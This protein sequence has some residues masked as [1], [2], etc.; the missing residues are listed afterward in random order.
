[1]YTIIN[2]KK[3]SSCSQSDVFQNANAYDI[4]KYLGEHLSSGSIFVFWYSVETLLT[5]RPHRTSA[6][7]GVT[8]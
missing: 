6:E 8:H 3:Q 5:I 2:D 7:A 4:R 1:M